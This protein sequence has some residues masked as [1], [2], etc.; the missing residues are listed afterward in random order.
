[1]GHFQPQGAQLRGRPLR[2]NRNL[3]HDELGV[4][5]APQYEW[6]LPAA[7]CAVFLGRDGDE[8]DTARLGHRRPRRLAGWKPV[9]VGRQV[10]RAG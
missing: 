5:L 1:M 7:V 8:W 9:P 6:R 10:P 2:Q 4:S 3:R